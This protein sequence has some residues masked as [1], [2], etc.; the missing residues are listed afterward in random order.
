MRAPISATGSEATRSTVVPIPWPRGAAVGDWRVVD[1]IGR[2]GTAEVWLGVAADGREAALKLVTPALRAHRNAAALV[3]HEL[4]VLRAVASPHLVRPLELI[5]Q[6][7]RS[8]LVLEHLPGG[9]LVALAGGPVEHWLPAF[10][11]VLAGLADLTA[12]GLA[13]GDVKARNVL[14]G[15]DGRARLSDL[16]GARQRT[17]PAR[18]ATA[19]YRVP[20]AATAEEADVFAAAAL[21]YELVTG[22]LPYGEAGAL[23]LEPPPTPAAIVE[24]RAVRLLGA[25]QAVLCAGGRP[26]CGL[27]YLADVIDTVGA[28]AR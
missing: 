19:A 13:H 14:F 20:A 6:G 16:A 7:P 17:A 12:R 8:V 2:G 23:C 22:H 21:L 15:A 27:S 10:R 28:A 24:P 3:R 18:P 1:L 9:D 26:P 5:E 25:A 11:S 4:D